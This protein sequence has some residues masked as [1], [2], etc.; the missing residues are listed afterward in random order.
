MKTKLKRKHQFLKTAIKKIL[1]NSVY[2]QTKQKQE[3]FTVSRDY[4]KT[5]K[6]P[7]HLLERTVCFFWKQGTREIRVGEIFIWQN[8]SGIGKR[9]GNKGDEDLYLTKKNHKSNN[10]SKEKHIYQTIYLSNC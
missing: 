8:V 7:A 6:L 10:K 4:N 3:Y 9:I 5:Y 1:L 2:C